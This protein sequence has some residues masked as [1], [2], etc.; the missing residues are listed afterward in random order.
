[1]TA[2]QSHILIVDDDYSYAE[3]AQMLLQGAGHDAIICQNGKSGVEAAESEK[4]DLIVDF[5]TLTG[6]AR[7]AL[8]PDYPAL[9]TRKDETAQALIDAGRACDDEPW[10]LP[11]PAA[12]AEW[13]KSDVADINNAHSNGFAGASVAGIFLD[14]FVSEGIEWAHFDT[15]EIDRDI[16]VAIAAK[17]AEV[18]IED[19]RALNPSANKPVLLAAATPQILL[20][21]D[22]AKQFQI[23]LQAYNRGPLASWT[24]WVAPRTLK[25]ADAAKMV[26][27]KEAELRQVNK[28]PNGMLIRAGSTLDRKSTRLNSSHVRTSRMPSSA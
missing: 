17:L 20:P 19:F 23:N 22:N 2:D 21:W 9:M 11:L 16:D 26:S 18:S 24:A 8:G 12:Y 15:F 13:L 7:V 4:P 28:I 27:M 25:P 3:Y 14:K 1:M 6:A 10:R 5:A